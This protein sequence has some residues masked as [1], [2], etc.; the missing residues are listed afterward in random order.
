MASGSGAGTVQRVDRRLISLRGWLRSPE[1]RRVR[2]HVRSVF[3]KAAVDACPASGDRK[4]LHRGECSRSLERVV[5]GARGSP[6]SRAASWASVR[7]L[8]W[9][10]RGPV[11]NWRRSVA[12]IGRQALASG[13]LSAKRQNLIDPSRWNCRRDRPRSYKPEWAH[14]VFPNKVSSRS[15]PRP[16]SNCCEAVSAARVRSIRLGVQRRLPCNRP[17]SES[18]EKNLGYVGFL[19]NSEMDVL[20]RYY[21]AAASR[22]MRWPVVRITGECSL[23]LIRGA[24]SASLSAFRRAASI[25]PP[26]QPALRLSGWPGYRKKKKKVFSYRTLTT[27]WRVRRATQ[28]PRRDTLPFTCAIGSLSYRQS[29]AI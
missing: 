25:T 12:F 20:Y 13:D 26:H 10:S 28:H 27:A 1:S 17:M 15:V 16:G 6:Y 9:L 4:A 18:R 19:I 22:W 7:G 2:V 14:A 8:S 21:H 5:H 3:C 23:S 29:Y 11:L 24:W